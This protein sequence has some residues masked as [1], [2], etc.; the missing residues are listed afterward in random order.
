MLGEVS[1]LR[2]LCWVVCTERIGWKGGFREDLYCGGYG[3][4]G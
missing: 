1:V 4:G 2:G 3:I